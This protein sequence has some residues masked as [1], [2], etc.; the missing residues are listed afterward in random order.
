MSRHNPVRVGLV[1][2]WAGLRRVGAGPGLP[3][4]SLEFNLLPS[5][6]YATKSLVYI[7]N[8]DLAPTSIQDGNALVKQHGSL[9]N[10]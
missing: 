5:Y 1:M 7:R 9:K 8:V 2:G 3:S 6:N 4:L 10:S